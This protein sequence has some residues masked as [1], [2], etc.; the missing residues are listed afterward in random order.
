L[1]ELEKKVFEKEWLENIL[2]RLLK[3]T[4][5]EGTYGKTVELSTE[6][7]QNLRK[8]LARTGKREIVER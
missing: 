4:S 8:E 6:W 1:I 3:L 5:K 7:Y 2:R